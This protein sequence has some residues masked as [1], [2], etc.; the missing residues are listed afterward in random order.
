[1]AAPT[2]ASVTETDFATSVTS[3][4]VNT[5][6]SLSSGDLLIALVHVRNSGTWTVPS[7]WTEFGSQ[8]GGGSVGESTYFYKAADGSEENTT[9]TWTAGTGTTAAWQMLRITNWHGST[10]PEVATTSGDV[11]SADPPSLNPSNWGTEETLWL[12]VAGHSA[13]ST[14]P[15]SAAPSGYSGF[16]QNGASSGGAA[17]AI[18]HGYL[19]NEADSED[20]GAFT[21]SGSNRFWAA[22]T[23]AIRPADYEFSA[24]VV[25]GGGGGSGGDSI[26]DGGGG[27]GGGGFKANTSLGLLESTSYTIT[28]GAGGAGGVLEAGTGGADGSDSS[29]GTTLVSDGGGGGGDVDSNGNT[30]GSGGGGGEEGGSGGSGTAGQGNAGGDSASDNAAGGGGGAGASGSNGSAGDGGNGGNGSA[31]TITGSSVTYAG[32]GGGGGEDTGGSGGTG[33]GGDGSVESSTTAPTAGTDNLGGG[34]GGAVH[35]DDNG[36]DGGDGV[37]IIRFTTADLTIDD[38][39]NGTSNTDGDDTYITWNSSGS[40]EFSVGGGGGGNRQRYNLPTMGVS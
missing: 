11:S 4:A 38:M 5:P 17:T 35:N 12:A 31:S 36:A 25:A 34:G 14:T 16:A 3:M 23:I 30:G 9:L 26:R 15:F 21:V 33:G 24:L 37:V 28:I 27:G 32:G 40:F 1:M 8:L 22:A 19:G 18:A 10:A 13:I 2:L 20:P 29:I 39:T 6:A 7:G